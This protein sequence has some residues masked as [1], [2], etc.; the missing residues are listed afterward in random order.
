MRTSILKVLSVLLLA[1]MSC[2]SAQAKWWIFGKS[3]TEVE[4]HYLYINNMSFMEKSEAITLYRDTL[5]DG[6]VKIRGKGKTK[7]KVGAVEVSLNNKETWQ[8][9]KLSDDGAF[10]FTFKPELGKTYD[11]FIKVLDTTGKSN[12]IDDTYRKI[13]LSD[14]N[15]LAMVREALQKL[16]EAYRSENPSAFMALVS[17][18][19]AGDYILLDRAIRKDFAN[20]DQIDLRFTISSVA[21]GSKGRVSVSL[22]FNRFLISTRSAQSFTDKGTTEFVFEQ[23]EDK[24]L[25][26]S[27]KNPL[28]FGLSDASNI[29]TGSVLIAD[30]QN[31]LVVDES[32]NI[33]QLPF[34]QGLDA[35]NN[36]GA[37]G[38]GGGGAGFVTLTNLRIVGGQVHHFLE[39]EFDS[40][41][42][43]MTTPPMTY[44]TIVEES[45]SPGGPWVEVGR[46]DYDTY[47]Q[48]S[49][50]AI[51]QEEVLLY[52][53]VR[54]Q[55]LADGALSAPSNVVVFD[56]R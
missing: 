38:G 4:F 14:R 24:L 55:R 5:P 25:V 26:W 2:S 30:N 11:L 39:I 54:V 19:F 52:Y 31:I 34:Q 46:K 3:D 20:F 53:R 45:R 49:T 29:A 42:D 36:G 47:V 21:T 32:G 40:T 43:M 23:K 9:A 44:E 12:R 17:E 51:A 6:V 35:I 1:V 8:P 13:T 41:L 50:D 16:V 56:N 18:D 22:L 15:L 7:G 33:Q 48:V 10:E 27:M 28:I 37:G